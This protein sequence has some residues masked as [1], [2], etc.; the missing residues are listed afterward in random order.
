MATTTVQIDT[1]LLERLRERA[2]GKSDRELLEEIATI[3]LGFETIARL[4]QRNADADD[5]EVMAEAVKA[6]HEIR[7]ESRE[8][9]A[10]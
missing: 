5:D 2:P 6:V 10:G 7:S 8:R 3:T 4:Q 1:A 9:R